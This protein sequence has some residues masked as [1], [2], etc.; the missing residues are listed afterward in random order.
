MSKRDYYEVLGV[1]R[2][3]NQ[4]QIKKSFRRLAMKYHPDRNPNDDSA[5][6]KFKEARE[7]YEVLAD[8][9]KR[10][11]Y[12]QFGH[13][14][15]SQGPGGFGGGASVNAED[16]FS[17][18]E[19]IFGDI[20]GGGRGRRQRGGGVRVQPGAD[21]GYELTLTL[22]E[23]VAGKTVPIEV[24]THIKCDTC[25]GSGA[26]SGATPQV[27]QQ[28]G[29]QGQVRMQQG[30]FVVQQTCPVCHGTGTVISDP[31]AACHGQGRKKD[32]KKLSVKIPP[33]INDGDRI[34]LSGEGEAGIQGAPAGDLYVQIHVQ[35]HDIFTREGEDLHCEVPISFVAAAIGGQVEIP[36]LDGKVKL[37]IPAETQAG[38]LFRLRG[39]GVKSVR[40]RGVGD[41]FCRVIVETPV[42]LSKQQKEALKDFDLSL[43]K[44]TI[45]HSPRAKSFFDKVKNFFERIAS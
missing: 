5:A 21:L 23:A 37:K 1:S 38:K 39:K 41:L 4:D 2:D 12:D 28:C 13:A 18:F 24:F 35:K 30:F 3:A 42:N 34:R 22:E 14:G 9:Q 45:N 15:V 33:G 6:T 25:N 36:T 43:E 7:A 10:Q 44:D 31:C 29:G 26:K 17:G 40:G 20:F 16:I 8:S 11:A 19:D 27:C 32:R